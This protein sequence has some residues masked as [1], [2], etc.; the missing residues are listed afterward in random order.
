[1]KIIQ[2]KPEEE[3]REGF[4]VSEKRK[5]VWNVELELLQVVLDVC[6]KYNLRIW[7][8]SGTLLGAVRHHGFIPWDDDIDLIMFREEYDKLVEIGSREFSSPYF[9]QTAYTDTGYYRAHIQIRMEGTTGILLGEYD[10]TFNQGIFID[11]FPLDAVIE[12][13]QKLEQQLIKAREFKELLWTPQKLKLPITPRLSALLSEYFRWRKAKKMFSDKTRLELFREYEDLFRSV[14]ISDHKYVRTIA[15]LFAIRYIDKHIFD[16]TIYLNFEGVSV[17][18]PRNYDAYLRELY[19]PTYLKP[20][21][22]QTIHGSVIFDPD[23]SYKTYIPILKKE[24]SQWKEFIRRI[25]KRIYHI[26][27]IPLEET[28]MNL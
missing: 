24:H 15:C 27:S 3:V 12:D 4:L 5:K 6:K 10:R 11:I 2:I 16:N 18:V 20:K 23:K 7:V 9:F 13:S 28:L 1:M 8:D 14:K 25:K 22:A 21:R 26:S 17:P 19:G